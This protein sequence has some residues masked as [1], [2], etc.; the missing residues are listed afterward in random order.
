MTEFLT[1]SASASTGA[2]QPARHCA[3]TGCPPYDAA[4]EHLALSLPG[5]KRE[6]TVWLC[7][8]HQVQAREWVA[9]MELHF[10]LGVTTPGARSAFEEF[11]RVFESQFAMQD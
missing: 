7:R 4:A 8:S 10:S 3:A 6:W 2:A 11:T 5:F 1:A 9:D